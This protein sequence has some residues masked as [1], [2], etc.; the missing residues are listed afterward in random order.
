MAPV[1]SAPS[2]C[3]Y[4]G[5]RQPGFFERKGLSQISSR[6]LSHLGYYEKGA[7]VKLNNWTTLRNLKFRL[8]VYKLHEDCIDFLELVEKIYSLKEK[9]MVGRH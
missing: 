6:L 4:I 1:N 8:S 9:P 3:L 7:G 5:I 2:T